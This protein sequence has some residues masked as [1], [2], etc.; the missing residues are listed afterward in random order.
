MAYSCY[1]IPRL[2][3]LFS[4]S[5]LNRVKCAR[6]VGIVMSATINESSMLKR[7]LTKYSIHE[8]LAEK[9]IRNLNMTKNLELNIVNCHELEFTVLETLTRGN[10]SSG[11]QI[12]ASVKQTTDDNTS[13]KYHL[14]PSRRQA[15]EYSESITKGISSG[16]RI[17]QLMW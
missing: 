15:H 10:F 6:L 2:S 17:Q 14:Q 7:T 13:K 4:N 9:R 12:E 16:V 11:Q 8:M 5:T 1:I 3:L